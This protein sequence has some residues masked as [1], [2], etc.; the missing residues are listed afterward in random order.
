VIL[1]TRTKNKSKLDF[2]SLPGNNPEVLTVYLSSVIKT[3]CSSHKFVGFCGDNCNTEFGDV[4][5]QGENSDYILLRKGIR[6]NIVVLKY[7]SL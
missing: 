4:K 6:R 5:L 3:L 1:C 7:T 2:L